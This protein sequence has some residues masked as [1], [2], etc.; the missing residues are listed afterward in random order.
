MKPS[1][2][3]AGSLGS[4]GNPAISELIRTWERVNNAMF[5]Q[6]HFPDFLHFVQFEKNWFFYD[7]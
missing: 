2:M 6:K 7:L 3:F 5:G 4:C 1:F